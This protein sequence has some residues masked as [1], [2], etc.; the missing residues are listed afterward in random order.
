[1]CVQGHGQ[2]GGEESADEDRSLSQHDAWREG[3]RVTFPELDSREGGYQQP[4]AENT[5]PHLGV[6]P[7]VGRSTPL[8]SEQQAN[9][10]TDQ[11]EGTQEVDLADFLFE[12][13]VAVFSHR[14]L[15]EEEHGRDGDGS[16]GKID[17][18]APAP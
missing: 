17:I 10:G 7:R 13:Q 9:N 18:E 5:A 8:E 11:E 12:G 15:E 6:G 1:M 16:N 3:R 4:E 14:I 2:E